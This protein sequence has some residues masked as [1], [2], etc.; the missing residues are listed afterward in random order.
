MIAVAISF[1]KWKAI[2]KCRRYDV[3]WKR[4]IKLKR[5]NKPEHS[6]TLRECRF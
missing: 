5:I 6:R 4:V 1:K 2:L 3:F